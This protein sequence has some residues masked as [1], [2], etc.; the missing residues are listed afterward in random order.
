MTPAMNRQNIVN[1]FDS[2]ALTPSADLPAP[3]TATAPQRERIKRSSL[4]SHSLAGR[5]GLLREIGASYDVG[6]VTSA[7][8]EN[9][10]LQY[11]MLLPSRFHMYN[12]YDRAFTSMIYDQK[13][14][15]IIAAVEDVT[16]QQY[17]SMS[18]PPW[19]QSSYFEL[20]CY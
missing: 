12:P 11:T 15:N 16:Y 13:T 6:A 3:S 4:F 17:T 19:F 8:A 5:A 18:Y 14:R 7:W 1:E 9:L 10:G 20:T 2:L